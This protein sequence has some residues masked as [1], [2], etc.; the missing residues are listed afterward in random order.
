[1]AQVR[2]RQD[3]RELTA[4]L[5]GELDHHA[6]QAL[7]ERIDAEVFSVT[8][9]KLILDFEGVTFMDSSGVG[10][11]LGRNTLMKVLGGQLVIR[12]PPGQIVRI[13]KMA[14]IQ[15]EE[16]QEEVLMR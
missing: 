2:F 1:M 4:G 15:A 11:I 9:L 10:L 8:P 12:R 3:G 16:K 13:L 7:R 5:E 14:Q 6:V